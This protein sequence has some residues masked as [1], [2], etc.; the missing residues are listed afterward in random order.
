MLCS[1]WWGSCVLMAAH[2]VSPGNKLGK[3]VLWRSWAATSTQ[4]QDQQV[5]S[6]HTNKYTASILKGVVFE[7][8]WAAISTPHQYQ[9][10]HRINTNKY[11]A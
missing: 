5:N 11:T 8:S 1:L 9:Q 2:V 6:M 3:D 10:I 4:H 7:K